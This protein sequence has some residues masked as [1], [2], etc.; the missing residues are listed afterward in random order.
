MRF[1]SVIVLAFFVLQERTAFAWEKNVREE[2]GNYIAVGYSSNTDDLL[3]KKESCN[4]ARKELIQFLFGAAYVI[5]ENMIR[6]VGVVDVS[7]NLSADTGT[8]VLIGVASENSEEKD[9]VKCKLSYPVSESNLEK[10]RLKSV[11]RSASIKF[12]DIGDKDNLSKGTLEVISIPDG[13]KVI[14]DN[15]TWGVTPVR[16]YGKVSEGDHRL[17]IE[18]DNYRA[19]EEMIEVGRQTRIQKILK[20]ATAKLR[21]LT[22]PEKAIVKINGE[23]VGHSPTGFLEILAGQ[24]ITFK[25][26]HPEAQEYSQGLQLSADEEK[27]LDIKLPLKPSQFSVNVVPSKNVTIVVDGKERDYYQV[28]KWIQVPAGYHSLVISAPNH[29]SHLE[30]IQLKGGDRKALPTIE[31]EITEEVKEERKVASIKEI[32]VQAPPSQRIEDDRDSPR[33]ELSANWTYAKAIAAVPAIDTSVPGVSAQWNFN[34]FVG[35]HGSYWYGNVSAQ[36]PSDTV[37]YHYN[38]V[39][40]G[41]PLSIYPHFF[42]KFLDKFV[43]EP[44]W[45]FV[46]GTYA[47]KNVGTTSSANSQGVGLKASWQLWTKKSRLNYF[48]FGAGLFGDVGKFYSV[49]SGVTGTTPFSFGVEV[50]VGFF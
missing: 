48:R 17:R 38:R 40:A 39:H 12:N 7:T 15:E 49:P 31:L 41:V 46:S 50:L 24:Q 20:R 21:I 8:V 36:F 34:D 3:A 18:H 19:I 29:K 6:S 2:N 28:N 30:E 47:Y 23:E 43:F 4:E 13:A 33:L 27:T 22:T 5:N 9:A 16:I 25:V 26:S 10:E 45:I 32:E 44:H 35:L 14:L 11:D 37:T 1:L 42:S